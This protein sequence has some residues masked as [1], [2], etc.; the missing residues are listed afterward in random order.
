VRH[1]YIYEGE[2]GDCTVKEGEQ[3]GE[4]YQ[5]HDIIDAIAYVRR[6]R[7]EEEIVVSRY[8]SDGRHIHTGKI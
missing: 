6:Q 7:G 8:A 1:F 5:F 2:T 3:D 4:L